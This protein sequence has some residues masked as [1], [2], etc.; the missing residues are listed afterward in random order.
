MLKLMSQ[1]MRQRAVL[2]NVRRYREQG[3]LTDAI[4]ELEEHLRFLENSANANTPSILTARAVCLG[5][6]GELHY[7]M[8]N[9]SRAKTLCRSALN[10]CLICSDLSGVEA[11]ATNLFATGRGDAEKAMWAAMVTAA[12][13][14]KRVEEIPPILNRIG[15]AF[16]EE[17][18]VDP[19]VA[20]ARLAQEIACLVLGGLDPSHPDRIVKDELP[21]HNGI[22]YSPWTVE[23]RERPEGYRE[24][25]CM[26]AT[27]ALPSTAPLE[28]LVAESLSGYLQ[29]DRDLDF[30]SAS[31][32]ALRLQ[33]L[34][35]NDMGRR[36]LAIMA[37]RRTS[38]YNCPR[39]WAAKQQVDEL[40]RQWNAVAD[41]H[42]HPFAALPGE[43]A[44]NLWNRYGMSPMALAQSDKYQVY[45]GYDIRKGLRSVTDHEPWHGGPGTY[46][47]WRTLFDWERWPRRQEAASTAAKADAAH[48][49]VFVSHRWEELSHPDP[50]G[51]QL[52]ALNIGL[53]LALAA[54]LLIEPDTQT[55]SGLPEVFRRFLSV[56]MPDFLT[57]PPLKAWADRVAQEAG[58]CNAEEELCNQLH[59]LAEG[60]HADRLEAVQRRVLIWYDYVSMHQVPRS[61]QEQSEFRSELEQL[62]DI[63]ASATTVVI[64]SDEEYVNRAWCFLEICGG[65]R[66]SICELTPSRGSSMSFYASLNHWAHISDQLIASI[67]CNGVDSMAGTNLRTTEEGDLEIVAKLIG[68]LPLFGLVESDGSDLVGG[69]IP[70]PFRDK[71][72]IVDG[73]PEAPF[74]TELTVSM[75]EDFGDVAPPSSVRTALQTMAGSEQLTGPCGVW[76]YTT[77][78]LL[79]LSWAARVE[80]LYSHL[81]TAVSV[82]APSSVACT[83]ADSRSLGDDGMGWTRYIPSLV[84]TLIVITQADLPS[85]CRIYESVVRAHMAA[86]AVVVTYSP[87]TGSVKVERPAKPAP[88]KGREANVIVVPRVRRS[89]AR[90][91]YLLLSP[92]LTKEHVNAMAA[93]R[94]D[95][96]DSNLEQLNLPADELES[97]SRQRSLAEAV[98]RTTASCWEVFANECFTAD[99]WKGPSEVVKQLATIE[100]LVKLVTPVSNNPLIR[101]E[102]LYRILYGQREREQT[103][104]VTMPSRSR[105]ASA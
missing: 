23:V 58:S 28:L 48:L 82:P 69:S 96:T 37:T 43:R 55:G 33:H 100:R 53:T 61:P 9:E 104:S 15:A 94:L 35:A 42:V 89:T 66:K 27:G 70:M 72:W 12:Q 90:P 49:L 3:R 34:P 46:Y 99:A 29:V 74:T 40:S 39:P 68:R 67:N 62:N 17:R 95:P 20:C 4:E 76:I 30:W 26:P 77:Q 38:D 7:K 59:E 85:I 81:S 2:R 31:D 88:D 73:V 91:D 63:Q 44:D 79:S 105:S 102:T 32:A 21:T 103:I 45:T 14:T 51:R 8:G 11:Y 87:E 65:I 54:A 1:W 56:L 18:K 57:D 78:R 13:T 80:E 75:R 25:W 50:N 83:W 97:L 93:L 60:P 64:A 6:L 10:L 24:F 5:Q 19:F 52:L 98:S 92:N 36:E 84:D 41:T 47:A 22:D 16:L 71:R 101:R 86:G